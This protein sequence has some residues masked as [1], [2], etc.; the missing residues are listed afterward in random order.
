MDI[1][2]ALWLTLLVP[3]LIARALVPLLFVAPPKQ[4]NAFFAPTRTVVVA[5]LALALVPPLALGVRWDDGSCALY[6]VL[7][8]VDFW[9]FGLQLVE[10]FESRK[11]DGSSSGGEEEEEEA[12][13]LSRVTYFWVL[14]YVGGNWWRSKKEGNEGSNDD[15]RNLPTSVGQAEALDAFTR[16]W[17]SDKE[18]D[19][20]R[21]LARAIVR[22]FMGDLWISSG[23]QLAVYVSQVGLPVLVSR[24]LHH[25]N[26]QGE[27]NSS[28]SNDSGAAF[29]ALAIYSA[30]SVFAVIVE[31]NQIDMRDKI[32]LKIS[33]TLTALVHRALLDNPTT[34]TSEE[35]YTTAVHDTRALA[36]HIVKLSGNVWLP[37]RVVGGLYVFYRQ[38]G[39]WAVV[40]GISFILLYLPLRSTLIRKRTGAQERMARATVARIAM[41]TRMID[42]IVPL[43]LLNW[44][45]LLAR[46][47]QHVRETD[48]LQ[49]LGH[50]N[51]ANALLAFARAACRSCGPIVSLFIYSIATAGRS[52]GAGGG[53]GSGVLVTAEQVYVVQA[54]LRELFPLIIDVPHGFDSWWSARLPYAHISRIL[55]T[56][57]TRDTST[58]DTSGPDAAAVAAASV[59]V[60]GSFAWPSNENDGMRF[61]LSSS[62]STSVAAH[63]GQTVCV[64]GKVGA[65]KSSLLLAILGEMPAQCGAGASCGATSAPAA[66]VGYVSQAAWLMD[67]TVRANITFGR[68]YDAAWFR[69]VVSA[70]ELA[71]DLEHQWKQHGDLTAVGTGGTKVSGG[72]RMRIALA[73]AVYAKP[74]VVLLDDVLAMVDVYVGRRIIDNVLCG[75]NALLSGTTRIIVSS[76]SALLACADAVW[77]VADGAVRAV[78]P[79]SSSSSNMFSA[80][81]SNVLPVASIVTPPNSSGSTPAQAQHKEIPPP[82][83]QQ[84]QQPPNDKAEE[85]ERREVSQY[86]E[87]IRYMVRLCGWAPIVAHTATVAAQ[88]IAARKAQLWLAKQIPLSAQNNSNYHHFLLCSAWWAADITL[89]LAAQLWTD[90]VW[91]RAMFVKSH[92][93]LVH[94]VFDAPLRFFHAT[95]AGALLDLFTRS[96]ADVD[97]RMPQQVATLLSFGVKLLF[98]SWV[99]VT[100]HP[101][102]VVAMVAAVGAMALIMRATRAPLARFIGQINRTLPMVDHHVHEAIAGASAFRALRQTAFA[103]ATLASTLDSYARAQRAQ[104]S[105]ETWID[106]SMDLIREG[107]NIAAFAIALW[108]PPSHRGWADPAM[109]SLVNLCVTFHLARLQHLIR[110]SHTLR[111]SL[112]KAARYIRF[113][114]IEPENHHR[115]NQQQQLDSCWR[116]PA[117]GEIVFDRVCAKY[118]SSSSSGEGDKVEEEK[119]EAAMWALNDMSF[120]VLPGQHIGVVGRTGAGKTS[121]AMALFGLLTPTSGSICIDG[122]PIDSLEPRTLRSHLSIV[123]QDPQTIPSCSTTTTTVR[124]NLDPFAQRSDDTAALTAALEAVGLSHCTLE[125]SPELW[126]AGQ[127]QLLA[128]ARALLSSA[129]ILVLD[130]ATAHVGPEESAAI[131]LAI[132]R[133]FAHRTVITIAHRLDAVMHCHRVLVVRDGYVC[134][135]G[136]PRALLAQQNSLFSGLAR[137]ISHHQ[138]QPN[139]GS[140]CLLLPTAT[141]ATGGGPPTPP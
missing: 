55:R 13:L 38:V 30:T 87:P 74:D 64:V 132:R 51:V 66:A 109:L 21:R 35:A 14:R 57:L 81:E 137:Q 54:I 114:Q 113:T 82:H 56:L 67:G 3:P 32:A 95:S 26:R 7:V 59:S 23:L 19:S 1:R 72:Q 91:R 39:W 62:S 46:R 123:P 10:V 83:Q 128:L 6:G 60:S 102:L 45:G 49:P 92:R 96:Q 125:E 84:Q 24:I 75:P 76:H 41:L 9:L 70:C 36:S 40:A 115:Q 80:P 11:V 126:S 134:E 117:R 93:A 42:N 90:V 97:T 73:R 85:E 48:E 86:A 5:S 37:V 79:S 141:A 89:D 4:H 78:P 135:S 44:D 71:H 12:S 17:H 31:Q 119:E 101:A 16:N 43:R 53:G 100:F 20:E 118:F 121:I 99:I 69:T 58:G 138:Q 22:T 47:V 139:N 27:A 107:A 61:T 34:A 131:L 29:Q 105:V 8:A 52:Q 106:L 111:T 122:S 94:G 140:S 110:H 63:A 25:V 77:L 33:V 124:D 127:K 133:H 18:K 112:A 136:T 98:E 88:C 116:G 2:N 15:V 104:D 68:P 130:E 50:V 103:R 28:S 129:P 108:R 65:G 120:H